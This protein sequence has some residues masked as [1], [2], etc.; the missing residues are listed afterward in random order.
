[1]IHYLFHVSMNKKCIG[2]LVLILPQEGVGIREDLSYEGFPVEIFD[3]QVMILR[4]KVFASVKVFWMN[5]LVEG[6]TWEA[7]AY[8]ITLS[9]YF[10][11]IPI[12]D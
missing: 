2:Y 3:C 11:L 9:F 5:H 12:Q 7:E 1:M 8:V 4:N 6:V 10:S